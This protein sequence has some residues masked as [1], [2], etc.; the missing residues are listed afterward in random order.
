M[1]GGTMWSVVSVRAMTVED[2]DW[3][4]GLLAARALVRRQ[5]APWF[6]SPAADGAQKYRAWLRHLIEDPE[7]ASLRTDHGGAIATPTDAGFD[8]D[9]FA[10]DNPERYAD[11]GS[12][13]IAS[14]RAVGRL[15]LVVPFHETERLRLAEAIDWLE[16]GEVWWTQSLEDVP[17][18]TDPPDDL[19]AVPTK[20]DVE[21]A[22]AFM[23]PAP[24]VYQQER[25]VLGL[26]EVT[27]RDAVDEAERWAAKNGAGSATLMAA[28]DEDWA[29]LG[30]LRTT[31]FFSQR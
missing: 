19:D 10:V 21:G 11:D 15:R 29:D 16:L 23:V 25:P 20:T 30:Y 3:L 26:R 17:G 14:L 6:W 12:V 24:P 27:R 8:V 18:F 2:L 28:L 22:T 7:V 1:G 4:Q 31:G 9:D 13:L 5:F